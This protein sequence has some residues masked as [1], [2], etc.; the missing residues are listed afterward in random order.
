MIKSIERE[1]LPMWEIKRA[2]ECAR[3]ISLISTITTCLINKY[4]SSYSTFSFGFFKIEIWMNGSHFNFNRYEFLCFSGKTREYWLLTIYRC[5][6]KRKYWY[7]MISM[8]LPCLGEH[9][10]TAIYEGLILLHD[11]KI[12]IHS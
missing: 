9:G 2:D 8:L 4:F 10:L 3:W 7:K 11:E 12:R 5:F 1:M 6:A